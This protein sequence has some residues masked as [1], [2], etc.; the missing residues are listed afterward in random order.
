MMKGSNC[1]VTILLI[2]LRLPLNLC[3][4]GGHDALLE[5]NLGLYVEGWLIGVNHDSVYCQHDKEPL[6]HTQ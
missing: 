6:G 1:T 3:H 2:G 5:A 4:L